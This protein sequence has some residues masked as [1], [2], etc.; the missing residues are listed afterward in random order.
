LAQQ[1]GASGQSGVIA[2]QVESVVSDSES[3][4]VNVSLRTFAIAK[5]TDRLLTTSVAIT[6]APVTLSICLQSARGSG[7]QFRDVNEAS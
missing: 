3:D 4:I 2:S 6:R 5:A 7:H 1:V